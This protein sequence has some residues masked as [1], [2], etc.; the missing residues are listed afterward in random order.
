MLGGVVWGGAR[1]RDQTSDGSGVDDMADAL[2]LHDWQER[3]N[4]VDD[5][6]Q[7]DA[8]NSFPQRHRLD[9]SVS[10]ATDT[11]VIAEH[12]DAAET[13]DRE[14]CEVTHGSFRCCIADT[15]GNIRAS[16]GK[17]CFHVT[18][19]RRID[20]GK[21]HLHSLGNETLG[22]RQPN[23]TGSAGDDGYVPR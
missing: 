14:L 23:A 22:Q 17:T 6:V 13:L 20:V 4:A 19:L 18:Q 8:D 2:L 11:S 9:P 5:A 15:C 7:V 21:Q 16:L 12:V 10:H 3:P 1:S